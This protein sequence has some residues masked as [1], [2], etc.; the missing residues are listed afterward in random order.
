MIPA[1]PQG[2]PPRRMSLERPRRQSI[3]RSMLSLRTLALPVLLAAVAATLASDV[4]PADNAAGAKSFHE[5]HFV[6]LAYT[7]SPFGFSRGGWLTDWPEAEH[8]LMNGVRRLTL[9]DA[10]EENLRMAILDD[11]LFDY[12]WVYA[13]EVGGLSLTQPEAER[14]REYLL[15]GGF[16]MVDDF[17]GGAEW[18]GFADAMRRV[19]PDRPIVDIP[20]TDPVFHLLYDLDKSVQIPGIYST[21]RGM[22]YERVDGFPAHWRGI[23][24]D[25]GRL[26]VV[27]NFNMDLGDAWEHADIPDYALVYTSRAYKFAINYMLYAMTH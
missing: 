12:P 19:F 1:A 5:F 3:Y 27:I 8:H 15:R 24:D 18:D 14:L 13:V 11:K 22:T 16:L 2:F 9:L 23:Y 7:S 20:V 10:G 25:N 21:M 26:M 17:H 6:R 4:A